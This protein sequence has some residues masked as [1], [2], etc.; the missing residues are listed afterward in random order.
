[1]HKPTH[2]ITGDLCPLKDDACA[3]FL[4]VEMYLSLANAY[5][6]VDLCF[7]IPGSQHLPEVPPVVEKTEVETEGD[8]GTCHCDRTAEAPTMVVKL[9]LHVLRH[10][11]VGAAGLAQH[12]SEASDQTATAAKL[13]RVPV[14]VVGTQWMTAAASGQGCCWREN[15]AGAAVVAKLACHVG[16]AC[17]SSAN[18]ALLAFAAASWRR[19]QM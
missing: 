5:L 12:V 14:D 1:M 3:Y 9:L 10:G 8:H 7:Q 11:P 2:H 6:A 16:R 19:A 4:G 13:L 15:A 18:R 17:H